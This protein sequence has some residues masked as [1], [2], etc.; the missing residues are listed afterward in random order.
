MQGSNVG[1][2]LT[3]PPESIEAIR[4]AILDILNARADQKTIRVALKSMAETCRIS[5]VVI[6]GCSVT[7]PSREWPDVEP[8][9]DQTTDE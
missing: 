8:T 2:Q 1:I 5:D 4:V 9:Q 7:M 6:S 3:I